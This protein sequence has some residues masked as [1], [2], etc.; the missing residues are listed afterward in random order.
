MTNMTATLEERY[1]AL[2]ID[3]FSLSST[4]KRDHFDLELMRS[5]GMP[6]L[7]SGAFPLS[8]QENRAKMD[9]A[10]ILVEIPRIIGRMARASIMT[11]QCGV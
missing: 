11:E 9:I 2:R 6:A 10:K 5:G 1:E 3:I 8:T 7:I 4:K